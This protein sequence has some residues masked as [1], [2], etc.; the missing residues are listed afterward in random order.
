MRLIVCC[1]VG[2]L[3]AMTLP[4]AIAVLSVGYALSVLAPAQRAVAQRL[5]ALARPR[6]ADLDQL[7]PVTGTSGLEMLTASLSHV[8]PYR[9]S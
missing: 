2:S 8:D 3:I 4:P 1:T 7:C 9:T 6:P 5:C